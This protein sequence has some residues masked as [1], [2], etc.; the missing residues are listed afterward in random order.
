MIVTA[1]I[2]IIRSDAFASRDVQA[3]MGAAHHIL[4]YI[5]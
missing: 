4:N 5:I 3:T 1:K 2:L